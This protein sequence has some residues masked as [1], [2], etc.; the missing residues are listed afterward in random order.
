MYKIIRFYFNSS[1][2]NRT[3]QTGLTLEQAQHHC[4]DPNSSYKTC[5][6]KTGKSR[7]KK[8]GPWSDGYT[9]Q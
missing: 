1:I 3:I 4:S 7:T 6:T 2:P 8:I 9:K 5:T